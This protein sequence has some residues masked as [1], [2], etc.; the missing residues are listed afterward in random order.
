MVEKFCDRYGFNLIGPLQD[1]GSLA[2]QQV[3]HQ[4]FE[5]AAKIHRD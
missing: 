3:P 5:E 1:V 2:I 4:I